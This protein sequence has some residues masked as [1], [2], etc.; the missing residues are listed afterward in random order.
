MKA[1]ER[2]T[3]SFGGIGALAALVNEDAE[4]QPLPQVEP[5]FGKSPADRVL[6]RLIV[7]I[8]L[9]SLSS[10]LGLVL[11]LA[12][13]QADDWTRAV[14]VAPVLSFFL[15]VAL[16]IIV[17][18]CGA[19]L[20]IPPVAR[21]WRSSFWPAVAVMAVGIVLI[22]YGCVHQRFSG[23]AEANKQRAGIP[24]AYRTGY[25]VLLFALVFFPASQFPW[26]RRPAAK[27]QRSGL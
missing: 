3:A 27:L 22:V 1:T 8:L 5:A 20:C 13:N 25:P 24:E 16:M 26:N 6:I 10:A 23:D 2:T 9:G 19:I 18:P 15:T 14:V 12:T 17:V 7:T 11:T 21:W 4:G